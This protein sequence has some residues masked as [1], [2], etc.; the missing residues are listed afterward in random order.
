[1]LRAKER[2]SAETKTQIIQQVRDTMATEWPATASTAEAPAPQ[3]TGFYVLL[4][5]LIQSLQRDQWLTAVVAAVLIWL[6]LS[7]CL[8]SPVLGL[9]ALI[10]N[11][12]S[13]AVML[14]MVGW[15]GVPA[16]M[17]TVMIAAVSMGLAVD[18]SIHF[19]VAYR[20]LRRAGESVMQALI[21]VQQ[22]TGPALVW[23]TLSL[24]IGFTS[25]CN[26]QFVPTI[27]FGLYSSLAMLGGMLGNLIVLPLLLT[28]WERE[29]TN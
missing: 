19:L 4:S 25:L 13:I 1:M 17:G 12:L 22:G 27:H 8:R 20:Q 28:L 9:I 2:M 10:P 21:Q 5:S 26:S 15:S 18:S 3:L 6:L 29:V 24:I 7:L 16:N 23:A 11:L 14:G